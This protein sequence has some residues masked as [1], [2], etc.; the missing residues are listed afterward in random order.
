MPV[1]ERLGKYRVLSVLGEGAMGI[2]YKGFDPGIQRVVAL[3]TIRHGLELDDGSGASAGQ[4]FRTEAQAAGRLSH[5]GI[6]AVYDYGDEG[7]LA[8]I[9]MEYVEG[10][11]LARYLVK[12]RPFTDDDIA[13]IAVQL[14][15]ALQHAHANGVWH[16]DIKP[17]NLLLTHDGLLKIAD[18]GIARIDDNGLT[19]SG[20]VIGTPGYMAP[21]QVLG[22]PV[23]ARVDLYAV[24][25]LLYQLLLGQPPFSGNADVLMYKVVHEAPLLPSQF[26]DGAR[27]QG[28]DGLLATALAKEPQQRF[29]D[30]AAFAAA[31][32]AAVGRPVPARVAS[33]SLFAR[34]DLPTEVSA[35]VGASQPAASLPDHWDPA[36]LRQVEQ[37]LAQH[38]G[39]VA[40]L[41]LRR[42]ARACRDLPALQNRL[43]EQITEPAARAAFVAAVGALRTGTRTTLPPTRFGP[44]TGP[45]EPAVADDATRIAPRRGAEAVDDALI[46]RSTQLLAEHVGPI[47]GVIARRTASRH[48]R[49]AEYFAA[50]AEA[51]DDPGARQQF[52][53]A[54]GR[55]A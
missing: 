6:I 26:P 38:V 48:P 20:S 47:A 53:A 49:R 39:P 15:H 50:L 5:P 12:S 2:V 35:P 3:K 28:F 40:A 32:Q 17:A 21:E 24:G 7:E 36:V 44:R 51:V 22:L 27:R 13:S 34:P 25:V 18:F 52:W 31:L 19:L 8:Y 1:P 33:A 45:V 29:A 14:L 37:A 11:S 54:L 9:A 55:L 30:A 4:R 23:D 16:R 42:A 46:A 41:M 10:S 43:A